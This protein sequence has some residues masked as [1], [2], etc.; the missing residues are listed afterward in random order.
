M[1]KETVDAVVNQEASDGANEELEVV[2]VE[3][4]QGKLAQLQEMVEHLTGE[5]KKIKS[6]LKYREQVA[7]EAIEK[8]DRIAN[9]HKQL[10]QNAN[11]DDDMIQHLE[12]LQTELKK[13]D[14]L[15]K[16]IEFEKSKTEKLAALT[17][18]ARE[19]GL[20]ENYLDKLDRFIN[21]DEIDATKAATLRYQIDIF[22]S[23][24]P[25][26]FQANGKSVDSAL[27]TP[28]LATDPVSQYKEAFAKEQK[29]GLNADINKLYE[30]AKLIDGSKT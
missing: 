7:K 18:V 25:D 10:K 9:E 16:Q 20:K 17:K 23:N 6:D 22:K 12:K 28:K 15:L 29:K 30:L 2:D 11:K 27:P 21:L 19:Q 8:R 24:Y 5:N 14:D 1:T 3:E 13:K 26:M 4:L